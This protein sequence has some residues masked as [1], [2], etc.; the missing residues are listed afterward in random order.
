MEK[1]Q[2]FEKDAEMTEYILEMAHTGRSPQEWTSFVSKINDL[3]SQS[4]L[5]D[6]YQEVL[7]ENDR[8]KALS[9][10]EYI[11]R[12][13]EVLKHS[14]TLSLDDIEYVHDLMIHDK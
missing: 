1:K 4:E 2:A 8:L 6:K 10:P 11:L 13:K 14:D 7:D 5:N 9:I 3:Y 12:L